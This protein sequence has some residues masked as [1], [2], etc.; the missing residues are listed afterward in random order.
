MT[1]KINKK[2]IASILI[3]TLNTPY[4]FAGLPDW[5]DATQL[6]EGFEVQNYDDVLARKLVLT[7][8]VSLDSSQSIFGLY[9]SLQ[10]GE[11]DTTGGKI[12]RYYLNGHTLTVDV[13]EPHTWMR[14]YELGLEEKYNQ[15]YPD[16]DRYNDVY[17]DE[18]KIGFYFD[19]KD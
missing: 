11:N 12:N 19:N 9:P 5:Y 3:Y 8:D 18:G 4:L 2:I 6:P 14:D 15:Q 17:T 13:Q 10:Q 16:S 7:Q 1:N